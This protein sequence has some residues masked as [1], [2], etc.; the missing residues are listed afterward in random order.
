[1][2]EMPSYSSVCIGVWIEQGSRRENSNINGISHFIEHMLFK[3][4]T[5]RSSSEI[6]LAL[7]RVGGKLNAFTG[8]EFTCLHA[9]V[10]KEHLDLALDLISDLLYNSLFTE[11][12]IQK[13]KEVIIEEINLYED[14][15]AEYINDLFAQTIFP[16]HPLGQPIMG[17]REIIRDIK[18]NQVVDYFHANYN[19]GRFIVSIAGNISFEQAEKK[20][21][22]FFK[23]ASQSSEKSTPQEFLTTPQFKSQIKVFKRKLNQVH[24]CLGIPAVSQQNEKRYAFSIF[25]LVFGGGMSSRL[26]QNIREKY[27]L[28]YAISSYLVCF[29]DTGYLSVYAGTEHANLEKVIQ[30]I[31][32]EMKKLCEEGITQE[33]LNMA[34]G[35]F[36]GSLVLSMESTEARMSRLATS[37][38]Y[39]DRIVSMDEILERIEGVSLEDIKDIARE[40]LTR[41][42]ISITALGSNLQ[43]ERIGKLVQKVMR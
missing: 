37:R 28:V 22:S 4:T 36:R 39:L 33:E 15:P 17:K 38:I 34:K 5:S 2:E 10:L 12:D 14:T 35:Y 30:L 7:D 27:G 20:I 13:E 9:T 41:E 24:L 31:L 1:M 11:E 26:F 3:G 29:Y 21:S 43:E 18:R 23:T 40:Y 32:E 6:A 25:N 42:N 8:K 16:S 19:P